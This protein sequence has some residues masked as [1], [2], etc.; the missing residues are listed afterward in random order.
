MFTTRRILVTVA[1]A[2]ALAVG[3][4]TP[5]SANTGAVIVFTNEIS[6]LRV[7]D[8]PSGCHAFP[9]GAHVLFNDTRHSIT[10]YGDPLCL[11][12]ANPVSRVASG[13][14]THVSPIGSFRG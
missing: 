6:P 8:D 5:A 10:M 2:G 11:I 9:V 14:S 3:L 7:W 12:P 4:T 1:A 13:K